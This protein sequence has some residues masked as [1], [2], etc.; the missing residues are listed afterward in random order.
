[1]WKQRGR[2]AEQELLKLR[3]QQKVRHLCSVM[4]V[5]AAWVSILRL[6]CANSCL[7][8]GVWVVRHHRVATCQKSF[9]FRGQPGQQD[10]CPYVSPSAHFAFNKSSP[11]DGSARWVSF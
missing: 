2:Q 5:H 8:G 11:H 3:E 7:V 9:F 6:K 4:F 1:M 10:L